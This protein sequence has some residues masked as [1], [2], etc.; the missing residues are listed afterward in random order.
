MSDT[1]IQSV[2]QQM[3][4]LAQSGRAGGGEAASGMPLVDGTAPPNEL[5][6]AAT[7]KDSIR[8]VN[9]LGKAS[10][11][12]QTRFEL[13]DPDVSLPQVM[14]AGGK[15]GLAFEAASQIRNRLLT[16]YQEVMR[17]SV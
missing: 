15:A 11:E 14:V 16:A 8:A 10:G 17:M 5:N 9:A 4:T 3:R 6:F 13:G 1:N 2:V 7:L 12:L